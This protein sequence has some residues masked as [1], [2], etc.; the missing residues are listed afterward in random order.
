MDLGC[1]LGLMGRG[2]VGAGRPA[3]GCLEKGKFSTMTKPKKNNLNPMLV[4][5][6]KSKIRLGL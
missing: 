4:V 2:N 3:N 5:F 6:V 1:K